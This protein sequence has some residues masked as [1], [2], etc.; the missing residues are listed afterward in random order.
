MGGGGQACRQADR[1]K[2]QKPLCVGRNTKLVSPSLTFLLPSAAPWH[3]ASPIHVS[4]VHVP[5]AL[6]LDTQK[7][8]HKLD[9][10]LNFLGDL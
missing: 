8:L 1:D 2:H 6:P 5:A 3:A 9:V 10:S 4:G 7:E